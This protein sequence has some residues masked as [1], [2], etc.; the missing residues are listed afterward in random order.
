MASARHSSP[1]PPALR[2]LQ[3]N[4]APQVRWKHE[5]HAL[6]FGA[7]IG[8]VVCS[9]LSLVPV[10]IAWHLYSANIWISTLGWFLLPPFLLLATLIPLYIARLLLNELGSGLRRSNWSVR[11]TDQELLVN[12]RSWRNWRLG[13]DERTVLAL[14]WAAIHSV[15]GIHEEWRVLP[16]QGVRRRFKSCV[17]LQLQPGVDVHTIEAAVNAETLRVLTHPRFVRGVAVWNDVPA[18][19]DEDGMLCIPRV[20]MSLLRALAR[21]VPRRARVARVV[22]VGQ[23]HLFQTAGVSQA[24]LRAL[25]LRSEWGLA[26]MTAQFRMGMSYDESVRLIEQLFSRSRA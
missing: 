15:G 19:I 3:P 9:L 4:D 14:P 16:K 2:W 8:V 23:E 7:A 13:H 26:Q 11:I 22:T 1:I 12:L 10:A 17:A 6:P 25:V 5:Y 24:L 21:R 18:F 20:E